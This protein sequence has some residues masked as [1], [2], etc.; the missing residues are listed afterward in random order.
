MI[1]QVHSFL[2]NLYYEY[3]SSLGGTATPRYVFRKSDGVN[4]VTL[5]RSATSNVNLNG[6]LI[7]IQKTGSQLEM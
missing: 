2:L 7:V 1:N 6:D 5:T 3:S 4:T